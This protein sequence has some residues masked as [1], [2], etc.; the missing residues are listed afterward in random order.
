[1]PRRSPAITN[2]RQHQR[3]WGTGRAPSYVCWGHLDRSG[4]VR[5]PSEPKEGGCRARIEVPRAPGANPYLAFAVLIA[6]GLDGIG[7]RVVPE[8]RTTCETCR[9]RSAGHGCHAGLVVGRRAGHETDLVASSLGEQVFDYVYRNKRKGVDR[10]RQL[11]A[12]ELEQFL[13]VV[14]R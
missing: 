13:K 8:A 3:L 14:P 11:R 5:V 2:Q 10:C 1:M 4:T 7:R 6:A 12:Q 9:I